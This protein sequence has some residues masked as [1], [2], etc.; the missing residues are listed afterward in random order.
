VPPEIVNV[1]TPPLT[2]MTVTLPGTIMSGDGVGVGVGVGV[3]DGVEVPDT[4]TVVWPVI[5]PV[6]AVM[7]SF[8]LPETD[9]GAVNV[10]VAIPPVVWLNGLIPP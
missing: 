7:V 4:V 2:P 8:R 5:P 6:A 1:V 10:T 9:A 3:G